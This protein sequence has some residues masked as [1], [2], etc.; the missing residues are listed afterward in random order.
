M[1]RYV[2]GQPG[3]AERKA[4]QV[5]DLRYLLQPCSRRA[6]CAMRRPAHRQ[7]RHCR[8]PSVATPRLTTITLRARGRKPLG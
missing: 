4:W 7:S 2:T 5:L 3:A 8:L 1:K 6:Q